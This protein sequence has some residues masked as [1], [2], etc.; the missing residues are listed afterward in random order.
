MKGSRAT[1]Y[2]EHELPPFR[3]R[4]NMA[5]ATSETWRPQ[6]FSATTTRLSVILAAVR[7]F[8]DIQAGSAWRDLSAVLPLLQG[9]VLD[10]GCGA[11]PFR[12]LVSP[13]A[14]YLGIDTDAAK[15]HFGYEMPNTTYFSGDVWPIGDS[16]VNVVLCTET[17][18]HVL[19]TRRF[20][21]EAARCL[22]PDGTLLLTIPF[23][24]R[25]HFIPYDYWR[26]TPSSLDYLLKTTGFHSVRVYARGNAYTVAC[27]KVMTLLL[28]LLMPQTVS[29]VSSLLLRLVGLV[30]LPLFIALAVLANISLRYGGDDCLGYTVFAVRAGRVCLSG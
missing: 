7:R 30:F 1:L 18:E 17:L 12:S 16:S 11:Q 2:P 28:L 3:R 10:V 4:Q 9:T 24:A 14:T 25:W 21:S 20:L 23:A 8:F 13:R 26:F 22:A 6:L 15:A 19:E 29:K 27:Y 5:E